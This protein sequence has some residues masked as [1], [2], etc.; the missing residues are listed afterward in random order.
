[1]GKQE[2]PFS[3]KIVRALLDAHTSITEI[4]YLYLKIVE[5]RRAG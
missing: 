2:Q 3:S 5:S 4:K 1:M